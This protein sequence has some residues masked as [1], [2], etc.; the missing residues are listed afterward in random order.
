MTSHISLSPNLENDD[1][2]LS[3]RLLLTPW[4]K[5]KKAQQELINSLNK[6]FPN[7]K[8]YLTNS[9]RSAMYLALKA[10]TLPATSEIILQSFTCSA[11]VNPILNAKLVPKYA[12]LDLKNFNLDPKNL[13]KLFSKKTKAVLVQHTFGTPA[14][15]EEISSF[16]K[17]KNI[18]LIEDCAHA[19]G[20][21]HKQ[22]PVGNFGDFALL[23]FGRDKV[24]SSVFGGALIVNNQELVSKIDREYS[25]MTTPPLT[26][27]TQQLL[28]PL[29]TKIALS[30]YSLG[31]GKALLV[32]FQKSKLLSKAIYGSEKKH[33]HPKILTHRLPEPLASLALNQFKKLSRFNTH[34]QTITKIYHQEITNKHIT[35]P[36]WN[37]N[38]IYLR[39]NILSKYSDQLSNFL[40]Q[41]DFITGDWYQQPITP[42]NDLKKA[43]Y[44]S[45]SNPN[46]EIACQQSLNLP[47]NPTLSIKKAKEIVKLINSWSPSNK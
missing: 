42:S 3:L 7:S 17:K 33:I 10:L 11:V 21:T 13:P 32:M 23:S 16:A 44:T 5:Q 40:K 2:L 38:S 34:R 18:L 25:K 41:N 29:L 43:H 45:G 47:T 12:D 14:N 28:H 27:T 1:L 20:A 19:L 35:K 31:I 30:C 4:S 36:I 22:K 9:A 15:L 39:Y 24:I 37:D 6:L 26:W 46:T 8:I